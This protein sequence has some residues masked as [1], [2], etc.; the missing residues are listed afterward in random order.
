MILKI[1][2]TISLTVIFFQLT[3]NS[4][5]AKDFKIIDDNILQIDSNKKNDKIVTKDDKISNQNKSPSFSNFKGFSTA[6]TLEKARGFSQENVYVNNKKIS[7][8]NWK[9]RD[10]KMVRLNFGLDIDEFFSINTSYATSFDNS[11]KSYMTDYDW[12]GNPGGDDGNQNHN[13]WTHY[14]YSSTTTKIQEFDIN[15]LTKFFKHFG[16][17]LGYREHR[18]NFNDSLQKINYSCTQASFNNNECN[19][20]AFR[21]IF[22]NYNG[23]N[24]INYYQ[25][26]RIPYIGAN[27]SYRLLNNKLKF[28]IYTAYSN[29]VNA[30]SRDHH[31]LR[32]LEITSEFKNGKYYNF[33]TNIGYLIYKNLSLNLGFDYFEIPEIRGNSVYNYYNNNNLFGNANGAGISNKTQRLSL[34]LKY[35]F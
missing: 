23:I 32:S 14:S 13:D 3:A 1:F 9:F 27:F 35:D 18:F 30:Y 7:E 22:Q 31:V 2:K 33:G 10:V 19:P 21:N 5:L 16:L 12:M 17:S 15:S 6:I 29:L 24:A 8:L 11:S 20:I 28:N 4:A 25:Q 26:F 34:G